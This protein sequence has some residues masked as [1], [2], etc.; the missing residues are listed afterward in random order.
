MPFTMKCCAPVAVRFI[1]DKPPV[2]QGAQQLVSTS[3]RQSGAE[4]Q[5][6]P[7]QAL[8]GNW[9]EWYGAG[10]TATIRSHTEKLCLHTPLQQCCPLQRGSQC[11]HQQQPNGGVE[12]MTLWP[13][14]KEVRLGGAAVVV[15]CGGWCGWWCSGG[16]G[17]TSAM[18]RRQVK[19]ICTA[20][21]FD[22][23]GQLSYGK[24]SFMFVGTARAGG[25]KY[26]RFRAFYGSPLR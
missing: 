17:G 19:L 15:L 16:A 7:L 18:E 24:L 2:M 20:S 11:V 23:K 3:W 25:N 1:I 6:A 22:R 13:T 12:G 5:G 14:S 10:A 21:C 4:I 26:Q 8:L 9:Q